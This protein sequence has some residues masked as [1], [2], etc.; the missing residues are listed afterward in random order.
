MQV[1]NQVRSTLVGNL[2]GKVFSTEMHL[3][4]CK[5]K[6]WPE[7][8]NSSLSSLSEGLL[9]QLALT[10]WI[11]APKRALSGFILRTGNFNEVAVEREIMSY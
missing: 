5:G 2:R 9:C 1:I 3:P 10:H 7:A 8:W 4:R 11:N 6:H